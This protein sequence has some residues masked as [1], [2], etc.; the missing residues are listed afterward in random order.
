VA[1]FLSSFNPLEI[2]SDVAANLATFK[3]FRR[4]WDT[5]PNGAD[6]LPSRTSIL[7]TLSQIY[8]NPTKL[9]SKSTIGFFE[10]IF[11]SIRTMFSSHPILSVLFLIVFCGGTWLASKSRLR[12]SRLVSGL[13]GSGSGGFFHLDGKEGL[14]GSVG[15]GGGNG[16]VD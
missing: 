2:E 13:W 7:E 5:S 4:Y 12:R 3:Q 6:I 10:G 14:L 16:K 1:L 9:K 15:S 11:F 8:Q